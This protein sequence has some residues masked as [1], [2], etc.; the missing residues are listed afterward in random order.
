MKQPYMLPTV[1][2]EC[3]VDFTSYGLLLAHKYSIHGHK[4]ANPL[5]SE[6]NAFLTGIIAKGK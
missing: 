5:P 3:Q 1:C 4:A 6:A 2:K